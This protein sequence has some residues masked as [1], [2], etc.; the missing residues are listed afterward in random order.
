[1]T[2]LE[3]SLE[4]ERVEDNFTEGVEEYFTVEGREEKLGEEKD[5]ETSGID[6]GGE[7][8]VKG[9]NGEEE[10]LEV[11]VETETEDVE[12]VEEVEPEL[13]VELEFELELELELMLEL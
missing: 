11:D 2:S 13:V 3:V 8:E 12:G 7:D 6:R 4:D 5:V 9:T 1:M 10:K